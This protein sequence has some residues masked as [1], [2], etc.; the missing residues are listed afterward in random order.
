[1][2]R[3]V[4]GAVLYQEQNVPVWVEH[5]KI[6]P[7]VWEAMIGG[8]RHADLMSRGNHVAVHPLQTIMCL[9]IELTRPALPV[10]RLDWM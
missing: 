4:F 3:G 9:C 1:M 5:G 10:F 8:G 7:R 2:L 6:F